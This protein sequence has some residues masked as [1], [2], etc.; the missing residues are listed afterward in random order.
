M[1]L[2]EVN[3][4][5]EKYYKNTNTTYNKVKLCEK[6]GNG[7]NNCF[8]S[9]ADFKHFHSYTNMLEKALKQ[10]RICDVVKQ[11]KEFENN[12]E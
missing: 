2:D 3:W 12:P 6:V 7:I 4:E 11:M 9:I 5:M 10:D 1:C 8:S